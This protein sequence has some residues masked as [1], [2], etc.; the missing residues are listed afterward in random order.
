MKGNVHSWVLLL[1]TMN[2]NMARLL[3]PDGLIRVV[4]KLMMCP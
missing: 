3:T 2:L 4:Q 1:G